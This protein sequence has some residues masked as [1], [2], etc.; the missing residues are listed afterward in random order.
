MNVFAK[1]QFSQMGPSKEKYVEFHS[2]FRFEK[3]IHDCT[4]QCNV[5]EKNVFILKENEIQYKLFAIIN[6][7]TVSNN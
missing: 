5:G 4:E 1:D 7:H 3:S 6:L 2:F